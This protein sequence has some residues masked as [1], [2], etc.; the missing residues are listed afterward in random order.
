M[1][2]I[3]ENDGFFPPPWNMGEFPEKTEGWIEFQKALRKDPKYYSNDRE[4][5]IKFLD[6]LKPYSFD[7]DSNEHIDYLIDKF[8]SLPHSF[9]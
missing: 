8:M 4:F 7:Q 3:T 1:T 6:F 2:S 9:W 5:L